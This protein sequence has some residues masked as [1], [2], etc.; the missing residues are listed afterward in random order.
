MEQII[1]ALER[2][3]SCWQVKENFGEFGNCFLPHLYL[4]CP[5]TPDG[6]Q[7]SHHDSRVQL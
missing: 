2:E 6:Q 1:L 5:G 3:K 4:C 7:I